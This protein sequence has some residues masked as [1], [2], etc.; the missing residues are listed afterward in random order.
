MV[1]PFLR[2]T[3]GGRFFEPLVTQVTVENS[4][5]SSYKVPVVILNGF[6]GSGK[7]TL[8]R[9]LLSQAKKK[10][11][12]VCAI[13]NDMSELDIDGEILATGEAVESNSGILES[14]HN[15]VL[16]SKKGIEK[17][18][19]AL[20]K[21]LSTQEPALIIIETSGSCHPMPLI[22]YFKGQNQV[23][24]TGVFT[25]VDSLMLAHDYHYGKDLFPNMQRNIAQGKRDTVNLLVEQVLF[26]SHLFLTKGDRIEEGKLPQIAGYMQEINPSVTAHS[27][28]F[29]RLTLESLFDLKEY[30]YRKVA[31]LAQ[32]LKPVLE[33]EED[34]D[35]PYD[36]A[37]RVIKDDRPFHPQ[38]LWDVCHQYL[39][40]RIYRS[41]GFFWLASRDKFSPLWNQ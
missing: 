3:F 21:L 18:D 29:G 32:E 34:A 6:L 20:N 7:T 33:A 22:E 28:N 10:D 4:A 41:K 8:F 27:V 25:L 30:N 5:D 24:L 15:V 9:K 37:T 1:T 12:P 2:L 13:V 16:S 39:D 23:S 11:I 19:E 35:R 38:R 26:C 31:K 14:I 40:K 36:L 17:L